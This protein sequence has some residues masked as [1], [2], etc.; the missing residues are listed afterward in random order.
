[1]QRSNGN[2]EDPSVAAGMRSNHAIRGAVLPFMAHPS[3]SVSGAY[4]LRPQLALR[5]T[6]SGW[7]ARTDLPWNWQ[8]HGDP[9][10]ADFAM[11]SLHQAP[12]AATAL[13]GSLDHAILMGE[14]CGAADDEHLERLRCMSDYVS[15]MPLHDLAEEYGHEHARAAHSVVGS[16]WS[17]IAHLASPLAHLASTPFHMASDIAH[18]NWSKLAKDAMSPVSQAMHMAQPFGQM[19]SPF[20][21]MMRMVPGIG[22][23]AA[24]AVDL[25]AHPPSSFADMARFAMQQAPGFIPGVGPMMQQA[26]AWPGMPSMPFG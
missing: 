26:P 8:P 9:S 19:L 24:S 14:I 4:I 12:I 18:G 13:N 7:Q 21:G 1:V 16:F 11:S 10:P 22:P 2:I 25:A 15:G 3:Q 17:H 20:S 6:A 5:P 23:M